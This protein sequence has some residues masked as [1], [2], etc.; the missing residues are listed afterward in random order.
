M[1]ASRRYRG[2]AAESRALRQK[3]RLIRSLFVNADCTAV[4]QQQRLRRYCSIQAHTPAPGLTCGV[5]PCQQVVHPMGSS[6]PV[7]PHK[8]KVDAAVPE[9]HLQVEMAPSPAASTAS[10]AC[11]GLRVALKAAPWGHFSRHTAFTAAACRGCHPPHPSEIGMGLR[12]AVGG[13]HSP[14]S[15]R[16]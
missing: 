3:L 13:G 9:E 8:D 11:R 10:V 14:G 4:H 15:A 5:G 1:G 7:A 16:T 2:I 6:V 12:A